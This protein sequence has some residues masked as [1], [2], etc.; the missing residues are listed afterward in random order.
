MIWHKV[1]G[2]RHTVCLLFTK[3]KARGGHSTNVM[4]HRSLSDEHFL[5]FNAKSFL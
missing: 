5:I 1:N 4:M 2:V 3:P